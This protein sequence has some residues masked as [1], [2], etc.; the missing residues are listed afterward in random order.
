MT[1]DDVDFSDIPPITDEQWARS[2]RGRFY[3]PATED[4][5]RRVIVR[6]DA[7]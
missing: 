7:S 4:V 1:D 3:R 6:L 2:V 5:T